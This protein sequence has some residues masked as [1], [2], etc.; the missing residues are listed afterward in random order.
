MNIKYNGLTIEIDP[1]EI[2]SKTYDA[3]VP[4]GA[5]GICH[6]HYDGTITYDTLTS[7]TY[8][9]HLEIYRVSQNAVSDSDVGPEDILSPNEYQKLVDTYGD[10]ADYQDGEQVD[11]I[12]IDHEFGNYDERLKTCIIGDSADPEIRDTIA[13]QIA[14][15]YLNVEEIEIER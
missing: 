9:N 6:L 5:N 3:M 14:E 13:W 11:S 2:A 4:G 15:A 8:T 10:E 1:Y 7:G 12:I